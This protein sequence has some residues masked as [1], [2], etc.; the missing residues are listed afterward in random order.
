MTWTDKLEQLITKVEFLFLEEKAAIIDILTYPHA[1]ELDSYLGLDQL[2]LNPLQKSWTIVIFLHVM[3]KYSKGEHISYP[4]LLALMSSGLND[5]NAIEDAI[6]VLEVKQVMIKKTSRFRPRPEVT[7][8]V[9]PFTINKIMQQFPLPVFERDEINAKKLMV[10]LRDHGYDIIDFGSKDVQKSIDEFCSVN[11]FNFLKKLDAYKSIQGESKYL[12]ILLITGLLASDSDRYR[13]IKDSF[14][15]PINTNQLIMQLSKGDS[16]LIKLGFVDAEY[17]D[18][19]QE[20]LISLSAKAI[21]K[22]IPEKSELSPKEKTGGN[23]NMP[24]G[25]K[26]QTEQDFF[27]I[28]PNNLIDR[29]TLFYNQNLHEALDFYK[30]LLNKEDKIYRQNPAIKGRMI[31][32]FDGLPGTGKTAAAQQLARESNRDLVHVNWQTFR[33]QWV[34]QSEKNLQGL[35]EDIDKMAIKSKRI[36]VVLFN[37]AEAFLSQRIAINQSTDRMEN[38]LVSLLLEWLEKKDPFCIVIFTSNHRQLMDKAFERRIAHINFDLPDESTRIKIWHSLAGQHGLSDQQIHALAQYELAG[39][40]IA[41]GL[42]TY[43]LHQIAYEL[44]KLDMPLLHRLCKGQKW[45]EQKSAIGFK[46]VE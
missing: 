22:F 35:L 17:D 10:R 29:E 34:G 7:L 25:L 33:G 4:A 31:L 27:K 15:F 11:S 2:G 26:D 41:Q 16:K 5:M 1:K 44:E 36:P 38:N 46:T 23:G 8:E 20:V 32:M 37:E 30:N 9:V 19:T 3:A 18:F 12:L 21:D 6:R 45:M 42:K 39:A 40:E 28:I 43:N 24:Q 13:M 14:S